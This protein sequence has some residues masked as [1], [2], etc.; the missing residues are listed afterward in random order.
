MTGPRMRRLSRCPIPP[1]T[2]KAGE[3]G[4]RPGL[5]GRKKPTAGSGHTCLPN[6]RK[7]LIGQKKRPICRRKRLIRHKKRLIRRLEETPVKTGGVRTM[8]AYR[9]RLTRPKRRPLTGRMAQPKP[10]IRLTP[11]RPLRSRRRP[12]RA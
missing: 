9:Q 5:P 12:R 6:R 2:G 1:D 4:R 10:Q 7:R 11:L 8:D 3:N